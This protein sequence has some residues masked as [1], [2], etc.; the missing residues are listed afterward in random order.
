MKLIIKSSLIL[1]LLCSQLLISYGQPKEEYIKTVS[2]KTIHIAELD[3]RIKKIMDTIKMPGLSIV[4]INRAEIVYHDTFGVVNILTKEPIHKDHI[5]EGASL[6]KPIFAYFVMKMVEKGILDLDKPLYQY[7]PHPAVAKE[8]QED[9]K[10]IT[11]RMVLSHSTGF[12]NSSN[13]KEIELA[14]KPGTGYSYSGEAYQYLAAIIGQLNGVGWKS[15]FNKIFE[16]EVTIPLEMKNT[17]FL[18]NDYLAQHKV[19]GHQNG[20]PTDNDTGGWSGKT[21]NAFSSIHSEAYE[22]AKFIIAM[23]KQEGLSSA[24][25]NEMLLEQN[26]FQDDNEIKIETGQTGWGLGFA[27]KPTP[28]GLMHLH[29]GNNHDFQAYAMFIPEK[30]YGLVLFTNSD[31]LLPFIKELGKLIEEQF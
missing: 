4:I 24:S 8:S 12:P 26:H 9:Y 29:T 7:L 5:F 15:E 14:F 30:D 11:S 25:F 17:S 23:L 18:W 6:S 21:F 20:S 1:S 19:Y 27:Q 2:D 31:K 3:T 22:Y 13:G 10:L 28:N 16:S